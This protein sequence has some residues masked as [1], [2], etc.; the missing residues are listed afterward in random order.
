[1]TPPI[2]MRCLRPSV[3]HGKSFDENIDILFDEIV[4]A[5]Q[6]GRPSLLLAVHKSKFGQEKAEK[7]LEA[8]L[9]EKG[10]QVRSHRLQ[11]HA[12]P[13][14]R[15]W[16]AR[17]RGSGKVRVL[18]LQPGLGRRQRRQAGLSR[19]ELAPRA[20]RGRGDQGGLL[21]DGERGGQPASLCAGF[22][23]LPPPCGGVRQP[24]RCR[25]STPAG[26]DPGLGHAAVAGSIRKPTRRH[27]GPRGTAC[28]GSR[29]AWRRSRR[30]STSRPASRTCTGALG[31]LDAAMRHLEGW[32][33]PGCRAMHSRKKRPASSTVRESSSTRWGNMTLPWK[34][35][36]VA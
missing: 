10:F 17:Q 22:L 15:S 9:A 2:R 6:W 34:H 33:G 3:H 20:L 5:E 24:A 23:G 35:S 27:S 1:M 32:S 19:P 21:A 16:F 28:G 36:R 18:H 25:K 31:E 4:L 30:V 7:V 13:T 14:S 29:R 8:R 26:W 11:R 12:A